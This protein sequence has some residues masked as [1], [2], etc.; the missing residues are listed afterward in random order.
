MSPSRWSWRR[1]I[2]VAA[3]LLL[4]ASFID[5]EAATY[6]SSENTAEGDPIIVTPSMSE[7]KCQDICLYEEGGSWAY[8]VTQ[9][10]SCWCSSTKPEILLSLATCNLLCPGYPVDEY[11]G[12]GNGDFNYLAL[13]PKP[14][15]TGAG[16]ASKP[17]PKSHYT[18]SPTP[19]TSSYVPPVTRT[20]AETVTRTEVKSIHGSAVTK[21]PIYVTVNTI[22][23]TSPTGT[24]VTST[25]V[26]TVN[27][28]ATTE[29][30]TSFATSPPESGIRPQLTETHTGI[31]GG[32]IAGIVIGAIAAV[33]IIGFLMYFCC[34]RPR[35]D[36]NSHEEGEEG[37][38]RNTSV[39][40]KVGLLRSGSARNFA[41][42]PSATR[43]GASAAV[44]SSIS[45][46]P[47]RI[48]T[49]IP[50]VSGGPSSATT[51]ATMTSRR[52]SRPIF[53]DQRLNPNA[54]MVNENTSRTS[55]HTLQDNHDYSRPLEVRN[56]D[57]NR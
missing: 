20:V 17:S 9:N 21:R 19:E 57:P 12:S 50:G 11:C 51:N 27:G 38:N 31:S 24:P 2:P 36:G 30:V 5:A 13:G 46:R 16:A 47:P 23:T 4:H 33:A 40:S 3:A 42:S 15:A 54:L 39:L 10:E 34:C 22:V 26:V 35:R 53:V 44:P 37:L 6:C 25:I 55:I 56:P 43:I 49:D 45:S 14:T 29:T 52:D 7:G 41:P 48:Q 18:P 8:S 1:A 28:V 32:A